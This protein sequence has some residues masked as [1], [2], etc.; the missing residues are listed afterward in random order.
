VVRRALLVAVV[1]ASACDNGFK[2]ETLVDGLRV[3]SVRS[4]PAD[5]APGET[6][7]LEGLVLDPSRPDAGTTTL[8]LGCEPDP[9]NENRSSCSDPALLQDPGNFAGADGG[10][11]PGVTLLGLG[12][13]A[14][15]KTSST[16]FDVFPA[17]DPRRVSG[18]VAQV[19]AFA[20][21]A[22][23]PAGATPNDLQDLLAKVRSKE[24]ASLI[25][26]YRARI[27]EDPQRNANPVFQHLLV[28]GA[29]WPDGAHLVLKEL[30]PV[31]VD[32]D[33]PDAS[34][35]A[36]TNAT[37]NGPEQKTERIL[38]AWFSTSGR[39][40]E[41][42]TALREGV[43]TVFTGAGGKGDPVPGNRT[44]SMWIVLRDTRG[45]QAWQE[46][47]FVLCSP[48]LPTPN[49]TTV[50]APSNPAFPVTVD[51]DHLDYLVD[52]LV[53]EKALVHGGLNPATGYWE[54]TLPALPSGTY[55]VDFLSRSC[56]RHSTGQ[57]ITIP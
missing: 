56:G 25:T 40:S 7:S 11:P 5:L 29:A 28:N 23:I 54:G 17:G 13:K 33:V 52:V 26:L 2:P 34:F 32:V 49:V 22:E 9:Y 48:G 36:F 51:G 30:E 37:P 27:S 8:W 14:T 31:Q 45:G 4:T 20:V 43:K 53:G 16:L 3:L 38:A 35:E 21:A 12:A 46:V 50:R 41:A 24:I 44:G 55:S 39:F 10:L 19:L 1:A 42:R 57:T 18:T 6:A 47:P 15:L